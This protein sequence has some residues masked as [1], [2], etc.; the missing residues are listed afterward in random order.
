MYCE[1]IVIFQAFNFSQDI[2]VAPLVLSLSLIPF[3]IPSSNFTKF[4]LSLDVGM[5]SHIH[6]LQRCPPAVKSV[7][8]GCNM[9]FQGSES[10][11]GVASGTTPIRQ[12]IYPTFIS[13]MTS[14]CT[15]VLLCVHPGLLMF[16]AFALESFLLHC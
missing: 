8:C 9:V 13:S 14:T 6:V 11:S 16:L 15:D 4:L 5:H 7:H 12:I 10:S 3:E 2:H 1:H